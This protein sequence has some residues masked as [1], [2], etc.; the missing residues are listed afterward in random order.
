MGH[1][2]LQRRYSK[3]SAYSEKSDVPLTQL[4][5]QTLDESLHASVDEPLS[6]DVIP[7]SRHTEHS[8]PYFE[9]GLWK[10][11]I[12][13]DS[14]LSECEA[15]AQECM[16][17]D[18]FI[19]EL[20]AT[21]SKNDPLSPVSNRASPRIALSQRLHSI[22][23]RESSIHSQERNNSMLPMDKK[24]VPKWNAKAFK[25]FSW[26]GSDTLSESNDLSEKPEKGSPVILFLELYSIGHFSYKLPDWAIDD[27]SMVDIVQSR[28][29]IGPSLELDGNIIHDKSELNEAFLQPTMHQIIEEPS[30]PMLS[31]S[32]AE[33][34][35]KVA[36]ALE[37]LSNNNQSLSRQIS[38]HIRQTSMDN[39]E[40]QKQTTLQI[41]DEPSS[42]VLSCS[43]ALSNHSGT[44]SSLKIAL[45]LEELSTN[46]DSLSRQISEH[47]RQTSVESLSI[48]SIPT[49]KDRLQVIELPRSPEIMFVDE[50][51]IFANFS[52][53]EMTELL[54]SET[55]LS[56]A[57]YTNS[58]LRG[59]DE[60]KHLMNEP[61]NDQHSVKDDIKKH[62]SFLQKLDSL[63]ESG[64]PMAVFFE[65]V[66]FKAS[67][68][69]TIVPKHSWTSSMSQISKLEPQNIIG[70]CNSAPS[71][72]KKDDESTSSVVV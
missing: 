47:I 70:T 40:L 35:L 36:L 18:E 9:P 16:D 38:Q 28:V 2:T 10:A 30:G 8:I 55:H 42:P 44:E 25:T 27:E 46:N 17:D 31:C 23:K 57:N 15:F 21:E 66:S 64:T 48:M 49:G 54:F 56:S 53:D 4:G 62:D 60:S 29:E 61:K 11:M 26:N 22:M 69:T 52:N 12:S 51:D 67:S 33:S 58:I 59:T 14:L 45:A 41:I 72:S 1:T 20:E 65:P 39:G 43:S 63:G 32:S 34:G 71:D 3:Y 50:S 5:I 19:P 24:A 13:I 37:E 6:N 68:K 7:E